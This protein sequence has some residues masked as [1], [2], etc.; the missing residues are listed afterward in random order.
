MICRLCGGGRL[1]L[2]Y[3]E[4]PGA[5]YKYYRCPTCK[6]VNYDLSTGHDQG[7]YTEAY[8]SPTDDT[9]KSNRDQRES[10]EYLRRYVSAPG[11]MLDIGCG[12]A[13]LLYLARNDGWAVRGLDLSPEFASRVKQEVGID[14]TVEDFLEHEPV[15]KYDVVVLRHVL[16]HLIDPI[17]AMAKIKRL[18]HPDGLCLIEIPN[19][20]GH[21]KLFKRL[22]WRLQLRKPKR[23]PND[24]KPG[25]VNEYCRASFQFLAAKSGFEVVDWRTYSSRPVSDF[26]YRRLGIGNKARA[27]IRSDV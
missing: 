18:L 2:L 20:D 13:K 16:E 8:L 6:L 9:A 10:Y 15:E 25:H 4:G 24:E 11:R 26:V 14:I 3:A 5:D 1:F 27:L 12:N 21:S 19:I 7:Q 23:N 17:E 22:L